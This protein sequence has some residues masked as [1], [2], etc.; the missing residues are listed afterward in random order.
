MKTLT[1]GRDSFGF[2]SGRNGW[3]RKKQCCR[4]HIARRDHLAIGSANGGKRGSRLSFRF[5]MSV[6]GDT[7]FQMV[8]VAEN[9]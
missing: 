4:K 5:G 2:K 9:R 7:L 1:S 8:V 6:G 3:P